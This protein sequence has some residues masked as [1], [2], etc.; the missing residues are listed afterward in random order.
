MRIFIVED[1]PIIAEGLANTL[2]RHQFEVKICQNFESVVE[3][4]L[5]WPAHLVLMDINLPFQNGYYWCGQL[6]AHSQIPIIFI[7]SLSDQLDQMVALQMG[8]DDYLIKPIDL[9]LTVAKI[10][11]LLRRSYNYLPENKM[12]YIFDGMILNTQALTIEYQGEAIELTATE[13]QILFELFKKKGDYARRE[14]ILDACWQENNFIDDNTLA[15][16]ISRLR[17]KLSI[18]KRD[19][20]IGTK[21]NVGYCLLRNEG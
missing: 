8:G 7:S 18:L 3:E 10:Q 6:R 15:V 20:V 12:K 19:P 2:K 1:D 13:Y 4:C 9:Q 17:K 21:K 14:D 5:A 11:A 16:N